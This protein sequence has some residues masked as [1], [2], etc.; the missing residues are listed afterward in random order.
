MRLR[1]F[2]ESTIGNPLKF[3]LDI[4]FIN[5]E[6]IYF[7]DLG[8]NFLHTRPLKS[9]LNYSSPNLVANSSVSPGKFKENAVNFY[10][11]PENDSI[12][13][14]EFNNCLYSLMES[15]TR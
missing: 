1:L 5:E 15:F 9:W 2:L 14:I 12:N 7:V 10:K 4:K 13:S 8:Y 6:T 3:H 11:N